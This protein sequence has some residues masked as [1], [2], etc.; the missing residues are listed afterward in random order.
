MNKNQVEC[1]SLESQGN[2]KKEDHI[3]TAKEIQEKGYEYNI[4]PEPSK[5]CKG[6]GRDLYQRGVV[7][8]VA[9]RVMAWLGH[10]RCT[11]ERATE[12]WNKYDA[13][14]KEIKER[15]KREEENR[16]KREKIEKLLGESKI[17]KRFLNRTLDN[18]KV[19]SE[20]KD[21]F[22]STKLYIENFKSF[23]EAGE[24]LYYSGGFGTGK[25]HLAVSIAQELIKKGTPVI[26]MTAIDLLT[27]IRRTYDKNRNVSEYEI[28]KIYK[29]VDLLVIDDLGK[30]NC[31]DWAATML[32]DIIND[33]YEECLPTVITTNYNDED[34][35][36][37]LARKSNYET[38]GAIVSRLHE[39][40]MGITMNGEDRRRTGY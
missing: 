12:Y 1:G 16:I 4:E 34:L 19:D 9:N 7:L 29:E 32:Y 21:A 31:S 27:E 6:C 30:E 17:K 3:F 2:N 37:R 36:N 8:P 35:I 22:T 24:G 20:N 11:C 13:K 33:R 26:C 18:F 5:K 25:T 38:A 14:E 39:V 28:L 40:T 15:G 23:K 10:E